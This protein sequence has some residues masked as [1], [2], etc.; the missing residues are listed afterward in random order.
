MNQKFKTALLF[1]VLPL[2][3]VA[4]SVV[5]GTV[6][7]ASTGLPV[8]SASVLVKGTSNGT[9][10]DFD[11]NYTLG[12][13]PDGATIVFS[14]LGYTSQEIE[15]TGQA[16]IDVSL[17][18]NPS[19]LDAIVL[20]GYGSTTKENVTAAQTTVKTEEFNKGAIVSPGQLLAGKA[21]GVQV[22][23]ATGRPGDGPQIR[24]RAGSTLS[25]SAD[26]LYVVD[27][28]PLD[29]TNANLNTINPA[30]IE[31]F[32]ILK[33]ASATAIYGNRASNGVIIITTKKGKLSS[34]LEIGYGVQF[35]IDRTAERLDVLNGD[36][37]R[38]YMNE[39]G[40]ADQIALLGTAN[41]DWQNQIYQNGTQ[42]IHNITLQ[43]GYD[44]T[45]I[46]ANIA[47][48]NQN[49]VLKTSGYKRTSLNASVIQKLLKNDLKLTLN[50]QGALE[51]IRNADE[52]AIGSAIDFDPTQPVFDVNGPNGFF[53][54]FQS[55]GDIDPNAPRNPL[56]LLRSLRAQT[57][58][59]QIRTTLQ[60]DYKV[61]GVDGL[62]FN[63]TAGLDYN[64]FDS[65]SSRVNGSAVTLLNAGTAS[66]SNG[67]RVNQLLNARLDYKKDLERIDSKLELTAGSSYQ[68]FRRESTSF[69]QDNTGADIEPFQ[70]YNE[71]RLI[72]F[73]GRASIDIKDL[74]VLSASI[75]RDGTSR[76]S[77]DNRWG[78]FGGASAGL[79]LTNTDFVRNSSFISQLKVRGG[80]GVT[81]QQEIGQDFL[82]LN[83]ST[84]SNDQAQ[85]QIGDRFYTTI[86]PE[87]TTDLKWEETTQ[88][89]VGIDY[90][91]FDDRLTGSIDV[92]TRDTEDLLQFGPL[93]AGSLGNF[94]LQNVGA[95]RSRGIEL[96]AQVKLFK[97]ENFNWSVGGNLT[98]NEIEITDL[99]LGDND[100]PVPQTPVSGQGFNNFIQEWAVGADP[101]AFVVYRQVYDQEGNPLDGVFVD[102]NG[103][104]V[105]NSD[106]RVRYKQGN[107]DAFFGF[108]SNLN[109]KRFDMSFT[110]R[111]SVGGY[112]YNN[113][114]A[115]RENAVSVIENPGDFLNNST[116]GIL[117]NDFRSA[118]LNLLFSSEYIEKSDFVRLDNLSLGYTFNTDQVGIRASI[119][120][121]NLFTITNYSGLDPELGNGVD[122]AIFPRTR[123]VIFGLNFDF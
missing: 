32:T 79:K 31:S 44:N 33:D 30:E 3:A 114:R 45:A 83:R 13:V 93:A 57:D 38:S 18:E 34:D 109:Y 20:I 53:E 46:R 91:F 12:D 54:Y 110:L 40:S 103:D 80:F 58:N 117:D 24:V 85:V 121:T 19:E 104:N 73:F 52:G 55:N 25:A 78:T 1:L 68:G 99:S 48:T 7:D 105:I 14:Y 67:I 28:I 65:S 61:P 17:A 56:G 29:A 118:P 123:G 101:T 60:A 50:V 122:G 94:A 47:H 66:S 16:T 107:P 70:A 51:E 86:R 5:T 113:V 102:R 8:P 21:A 69:S 106:D 100:A 98:F 97:G 11:G 26:P 111:G 71:N 63:G 27:G 15:Y 64:E 77:P 88:Y 116:S 62:T 84:P 4:Q 96:D 39:V 9:A 90:G 82:Y 36:E 2:L 115:A 112:N 108:T 74:L 95:T 59:N 120:G 81:G 76:F 6:K 119:T 92:Y 22:T 49:G 43:K 37:F 42:A 10:T 35:A 87:L 89:N 72:S 23:A 41:T 75:S